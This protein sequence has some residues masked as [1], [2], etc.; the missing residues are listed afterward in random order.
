MKNKKPNRSRAAGFFKP[1]TGN[2]GIAA[3]LRGL[4]PSLSNKSL[5]VSIKIINLY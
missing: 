2:G 3:E 5:N 1:Q 4:T